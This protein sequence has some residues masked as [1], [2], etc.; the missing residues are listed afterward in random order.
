M[1]TATPAERRKEN[2]RRRI[3]EAADNMLAVEGALGL[4]I[5]RLAEI[6]DYS[7]AEIFWSKS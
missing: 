2:I 3:L 1:S 6:T 5:R 4:S 7:P